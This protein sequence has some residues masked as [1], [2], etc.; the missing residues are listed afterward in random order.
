MKVKI[1][2]KDGTPA[3][4]RGADRK[5]DIAITLS[6][7]RQGEPRRV[8]ITPEI[9]YDYVDASGDGCPDQRRQ[10]V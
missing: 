3:T 6:V 2:S 7:R 10:R 1:T 9:I 8:E 5:Y 4:Y